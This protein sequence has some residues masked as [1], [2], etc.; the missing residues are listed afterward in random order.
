MRDPS[1]YRARMRREWS[2]INAN[3]RPGAARIG[4]AEFLKVRRKMAPRRRR[5]L[6]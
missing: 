2:T 5:A 1:T 3:R 4:W 6:G